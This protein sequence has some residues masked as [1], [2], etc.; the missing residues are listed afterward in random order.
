MMCRTVS[1][2][3]FRPGERSFPGASRRRAGCPVGIAIRDTP[4]RR[5]L[6]LV[7]CFSPRLRSI[8]LTDR[9]SLRFRL[10]SG[11][12]DPRAPRMT[13]R[14][15]QA[16]SGR[17][18]VA[19]GSWRAQ[20]HRVGLGPYVLLLGEWAAVWARS[21]N[22]KHGHRASRVPMW[23]EMANLRG[24]DDISVHVRFAERFYM[25]TG[26]NSVT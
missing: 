24:I 6:V 8:S 7:L 11:R 23:S 21:S 16:P 9:P 17:D 2:G 19:C 22:S 14:R 12:R 4:G 18:D 3:R 5:V 1:R 10:R 26:P 20:R 15:G 25:F 13:S